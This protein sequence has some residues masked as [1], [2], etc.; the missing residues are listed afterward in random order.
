MKSVS[1]W[2]NQHQFFLAIVFVGAMAALVY[3]NTLANP[4]I[5]TEEEMI[6]GSDVHKNLANLPRFFMTQYWLE[7]DP[8]IMANIYRPI[9]AITFTIEYA[10]WG[11]NP[12]P[13]HVFNII[14]H[15]ATSIVIFIL[16]KKISKSFFIGLVTALFFAV[17][18]LH[19]ETITWICSRDEIMCTLFPLIAWWFFT[20]R[21]AHSM[22]G[23]KYLGWEMLFFT[24]GLLSR[25]MAMVFPILLVVYVISFYKKR[26]WKNGLMATLPYWVV[27]FFY[28]LYRFGFWWTN[29]AQTKINPS[30]NIPLFNHFLLII[31]TVGHYIWLL[32]APIRLAADHYFPVHVTMADL[33]VF[34]GL[35]ILAVCAFLT[36]YFYK[37]GLK[38]LFFGLVFMILAFLPA[39]NIL[40]LEGRPFG[41]QRAYLPSIGFCFLLAILFKKIFSKKKGLA[42]ILLALLIG[43]YSSKTWIYNYDWQSPLK[44]WTRSLE[45]SPNKIRA[46]NN[47]VYAYS[48]AGQTDKMIS[49]LEVIT[50]ILAK[51]RKQDVKNVEILLDLSGQPLQVQGGPVVNVLNYE[52]QVHQQLGVLY[53]NQGDYKKALY[54][55]NLAIL[56]NPNDFGSYNQM[57]MVY[58]KEGK[59]E[60]AISAYQRS[61]QIQ[62]DQLPSYEDLASAYRENKEYQKAAAIYQELIQAGAPNATSYYLELARIYLEL[63]DKTE[64]REYWQKYKART[65]EIDDKLEEEMETKFTNLQLSIYK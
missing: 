38:K 43:F 65:L 20:K 16:F 15:A 47:L 56:Y 5:W 29:L 22:Q 24:L 19:V 44:L 50:G 37:K 23:T 49:Q 25:E 21:L 57:G 34:S 11:L 12:L 10:L 36:V 28:T 48:Q 33:G 32:I 40:I 4:F 8:M 51:H 18:P 27:T 58:Q 53:K 30:V 7:E 59:I 62:P 52:S 55:F 61:I 6:I 54:Q 35:I 39:A 45:I 17:H 41:E 31:K 14:L 63:G 46:R 13:Y 64:A 1:S 3:L 9:R 60:A 2:I 26:Q 42:L